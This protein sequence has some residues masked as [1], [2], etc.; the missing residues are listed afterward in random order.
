[1]S[2]IATTFAHGNGPFSR[3]TEWAIALNDVRE[4][5]GF[6]R[7]PIVV[8]LVYPGRQERILR[9]EIGVNVSSDFLERHPTEIL[10]DRKHGELLAELMFKGKDYSENLE[11]L[12]REYQ[13]VEDETRKHLDGIRQVETF[14]GKIEE[15]D[16]RDAELQ[17]GL[18]NRMQTEL[19]NQFYTSGG[20]GPFD[21]LLER[22]I[23]DEDVTLDKDSMRRVLSIARRMIE[24]QRV[25]FSNE[26][27][28]F[29]Y[30]FTRTPREN[31][32]LTPPFV[33]PPKPD[34]TKLPGK[35]ILVTA[36]GIDGIRESGMYDAVAGLGMQLFAPEYT[37]SSLPE[38]I[39]GKVALLKPSQ[40]NNPNV[41]VHYARAGWSS[42]WISHLAEKGF[43]TPRYKSED[44]PEMLFNE[45]GIE[46]LELGAIIDDDPRATL[47]KALEL[48]EG[49]R[50]YNER[51]KQTYGTLDGIEYAAKVVADE[52]NY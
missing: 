25:I 28:V 7:L 38:K 30:D 14:N 13:R 43:L 42:V 19:P 49:T 37:I 29:S 48:A 33:H 8:P 31:E 40:I 21:E 50:G 39:R 26:P 35:G 34:E 23:G 44:D 2:Y 9:E 5:R 51:F 6:A 15:I 4:K 12:A 1:M 27:G 45:R 18:N 41:L 3:C 11:M 32:R 36:T 17:L 52:M 20:A 22:A 47:E 24:N 16:L 46:G 10:L